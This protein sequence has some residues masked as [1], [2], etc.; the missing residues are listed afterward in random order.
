MSFLASF[1]DVSTDS[2]AIL[3]D[4]LY[5]KTCFLFTFTNNVSV[6]LALTIYVLSCKMNTF[7]HIQ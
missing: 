4:K 7:G 2:S 1:S 3:L 6:K 5:D